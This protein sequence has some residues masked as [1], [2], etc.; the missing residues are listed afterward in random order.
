MKSKSA[1]KRPQPSKLTANLDDQ[2]AT[3]K[4]KKSDSRRQ[5]PKPK[6]YAIEKIVGRRTKQFTSK[7]GMNL[8][9]L[10]PLSCGLNNK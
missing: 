6:E 2:Q 8:T 5:P 3:K 7:A 10:D 1:Y 9:I 4:R